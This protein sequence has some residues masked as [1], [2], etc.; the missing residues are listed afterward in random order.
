MSFWNFL[1]DQWLIYVGWLLF[2]VLTILV[3]WLSPGMTVDLS[4]VGYL[5]LL[6]GALLLGFLLAH[7]YTRR[8]WWDKFKLSDEKAD[9]LQDYFD[10]AGSNDERLVQ[11]YLN[12]VL[13]EHQQTMQELIEKQQDQKEY[14]DSWVHEIKVPL[15]ATSLILNSIEDDIDEKKYLLLEN[16]LAQIDDYVEQV[17][18]YARLDNF[19]KDYLIQEYR[20]K[21]I[22][23][24]VIR[25][26]A[27]HFIQKGLQLEI[28]GE[29]YQV[30]T[31]A[32][33][34]S[35]I[36]RQLLSNAIKYTP[37]KGKIK[38]ILQREATGISLTVTDSG[39][40][41]PQED[42]KRIFDKGF[43][44]ENG[45]KSDHHSTGLGLYLAYNLAQKLNIDLAATSVEGQGTQM[46]MEFPMLKYYQDER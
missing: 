12:H 21:E 16:E 31:D 38:V 35:Y 23:Q 28:I 45:R 20:L 41:I 4:V 6:E 15:A 8:P 26:Q 40:G 25:T 43:T 3:L 29:D 39:I 27:N 33:W 24:P 22:I 32:K 13:V 11:D 7:Y 5:F 1:K 10:G 42:L 44:G 34:L 19:S 14:I 46:K 18:Y 37:E 30:L 2:I 36:F 9:V 17:L